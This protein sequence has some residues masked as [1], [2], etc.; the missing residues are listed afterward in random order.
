MSVESKVMR[1]VANVVSYMK[2]QIITDLLN[3][4]NQGV[5]NLERSEIEK[6]GRVIES[7]LDASFSKSSNE[8][9]SLTR[10]LKEK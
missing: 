5:L 7:S 8:I 3:A 10:N 4:S 6:L 1:S 2:Q 9:I